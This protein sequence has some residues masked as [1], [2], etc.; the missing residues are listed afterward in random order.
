MWKSNLAVLKGNGKL[1]RGGMK[2]V[3][4]SQML[5]LVVFYY[6]CALI[7]QFKILLSFAGNL[8]SFFGYSLFPV[9]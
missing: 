2:T 5:S 3:G 4:W 1:S 6:I 9:S 7:E 8:K